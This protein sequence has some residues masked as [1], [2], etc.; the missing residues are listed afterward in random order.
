MPFPTTGVLDTITYSDGY[1][2]YGGTNWSNPIFQGDGEHFVVVSNQLMDNSTVDLTGS[3]QAYWDVSFG[4]GAE[5]YIEYPA[6]WQAAGSDGQLFINTANEDTGALDGYRFRFSWSSGTTWSYGLRRE[7]DE[8]ST[9]L[10]SDSTMTFVAGDSLGLEHAVGGTITMHRKTSGTWSALGTRSD[11]T[12]TSGHIGISKGF[13]DTTSRLDNF[14]GGTT[15]AASGQPSA[16]RWG[17]IPGMKQFSG[18]G[19]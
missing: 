15:V 18:R 14:G 7:D 8:V 12:Y 10:G 16:R 13:N 3:A 9:T 1:L 2:D 6:L 5:V 17:D 19:F 11:N 4:P